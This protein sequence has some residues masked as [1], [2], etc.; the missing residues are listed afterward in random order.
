MAHSV[1]LT[2]EAKANVR[3]IADYIAQDSVVYARR[4]KQKIRERIRELRYF[5]EKHEIAF[6][7]DQVGRDVR[8]TFLGVYRILYT[9][10]DDRVIV[11]AVRHGAR[12]PPSI[13]DVRR[14][15]GDP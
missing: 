8:H 15:G 12:R 10:D 2:H 14:L 4:W 13:D 1:R 5:P 11:I 9:I 6:R 7:A 3:E